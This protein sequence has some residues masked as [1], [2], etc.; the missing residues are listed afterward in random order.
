[1]PL[2]PRIAAFQDDMTSWRRD[3]HAHPELGFEEVRTSGIVADKLESW[4]I[5]VHRGLGKTGVV[6]VLE[7][8]GPGKRIGLRADMDALPI[9]EET[10]LPYASRTPGVMHACGH[11][12]HT[13]ILLG[14]ARYLA[15]T[16]NFD[17]TA[18]FIFQPAEEG[19]GGARAMIADGLF[20]LFPCD[21]I[22][23]L[24]NYTDDAPGVLRVK[25]G[26]AM[27]GASFFD[28]RLRGRGSHAATPQKSRDPLVAAASLVGELQTILSRNVAATDRAVLSVTRMSA[29]ATHII[30]PHEAE[31]AG[32]IRYMARDTG[33]EIARRIEVICKGW[34]IAHEME[35]DVSFRNV[36]DVLH[37]DPE[38]ARNV[39]DVARTVL[40]PE[41]VSETDRYVMASEDMADMLAIVPGAYFTLGH[42]GEV[43][44]HNPGYVLDDGILAQ[45]AS[46]FASIV[47]A[48]GAR[49]CAD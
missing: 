19:L 6:G 45:G 36:F 29:G 41:D 43:P 46:V 21:E 31:L 37:N 30:V 18:I 3:F 10:N 24:H 42:A 17:G 14:A 47:E 44:V 49:G 40:A 5:K 20:D 26:A 11:D 38:L 39:V 25:P 1:M 27:A 32:T 33:A 12:S 13:A 7:G 8:R 9:Q 35:I 15:E 4:G 34:A 22:Y 28:I 23:G 48:R 2:I 16:R